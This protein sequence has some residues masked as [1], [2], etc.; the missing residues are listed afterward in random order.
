[1][2][3]VVEEMDLGYLSIFLKLGCGKEEI[4]KRR[5]KSAEVVGSFPR[6][7]QQA[8]KGMRKAGRRCGKDAEVFCSDG[9]RMGGLCTEARLSTPSTVGGAAVEEREWV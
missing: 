7:T 8:G 9:D 5:W 3:D 2:A 6:S 4:W 1:V